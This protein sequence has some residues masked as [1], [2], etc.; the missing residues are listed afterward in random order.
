MVI[1]VG[2]SVGKLTRINFHVK[3]H[4]LVSYNLQ[5]VLKL[6]IKY[7]NVFYVFTFCFKDV[8]FS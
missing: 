5:T 4:L 7:V 8:F 3:D 1:F 6:L 2:T